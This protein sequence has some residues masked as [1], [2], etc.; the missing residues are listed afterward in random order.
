MGDCR[1]KIK[2]SLK[3]LSTSVEEPGGWLVFTKVWSSDTTI[4]E[5][6][7]EHLDDA[8]VSINNLLRRREGFS[9]A[10][11]WDCTSYPPRDVTDWPL[12]IFSQTQGSHSKTLFAAGW[13]PSGSL[14]VLPADES[15]QLASRSQYDD[16]QYNVQQGEN[17]IVL[18]KKGKLTALT[19]TPTENVKPSELLRSVTSRFDRDDEKHR[20]LDAKAAQLRCE[21]LQLAKSKQKARNQRLEIRIRNLENAG[22]QKNRSVSSQVRNMLIKS[23]A[24]GAESLKMQDRV[25][26]YSILVDD[27]NEMCEPKEEYRY[28]SPQDTIGKIC[29]QFTLPG[30]VS[31]LL[32]WRSAESK[33][34]ARGDPYRRLPSPMRIYEAIGA[35]YLTGINKILI[36]FYRAG[37][38]EATPS[39]DNIAPIEIQDDKTK[40]SLIGSIPDI[41][42][43]VTSH[44]DVTAASQTK[45]S[46]V[47]QIDERL[48]LSIQALDEKSIKRKSSVTAQKVLQMKMKSKARGDSKRVKIEDRFFLELV[49]ATETESNYRCE[50]LPVFVALT[51][52]LERIVRDFVDHPGGCKGWEILVPNADSSV[53]LRGTQ[54]TM[55]LKELS[56]KGVIRQFNRIV[57]KLY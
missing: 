44:A 3:L 29:S 1:L 18:H 36:R 26:F 20:D 15:P 49:I 16:V 2:I 57:I 48:T 34:E 33:D 41:N 54:T 11:L 27:A 30:K 5:V 14:Q 19:P 46:C 25:Y 6:C 8:V 43:T 12:K 10:H 24:T 42:T 47:G 40:G 37:I 13:Y 38:D 28:Y 21:N 55:C 45:S 56:E 53:F 52:N 7:D 9:A 22:K 35:N 50:I 23:R 4:C 31:E 17:S 51:D 32:I 39:I